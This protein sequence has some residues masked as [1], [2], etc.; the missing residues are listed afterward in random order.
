[1]LKKVS[2]SL[3]GFY[4]WVKIIFSI[5]VKLIENTNFLLYIIYNETVLSQIMCI[6]F[7]ITY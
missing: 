2:Y 7:V 4:F 6:R 1:M 5:G 3:F